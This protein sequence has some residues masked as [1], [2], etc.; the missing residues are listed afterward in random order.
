M[1]AYNMGQNRVG[2]LTVSYGLYH[3]VELSSLVELVLDN[4]EALTDAALQFVS[5]VTLF[6][7][8]KRP[9]VCSNRNLDNSTFRGRR[10]FSF[11]E[12]FVD[13]IRHRQSRYIRVGHP[14]HWLILDLY[15][16]ISI[17]QGLKSAMGRRMG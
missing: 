3:F 10:G 14:T 4:L 15:N 11:V 17:F 7:T 8:K 16:L 6:H 13:P 12:L 9:P 5:R 1:P 2:K